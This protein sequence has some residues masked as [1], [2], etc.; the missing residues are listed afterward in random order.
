MLPAQAV[1][2]DTFSDNIAD[3]LQSHA[4]ARKWPSQLMSCA[5]GLQMP[6][7]STAV[8]RSSASIA[9]DP[10]SIL[11]GLGERAQFLARHVRAVV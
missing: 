1:H 5:Q 11:T 2:R 9:I 4:A 10:T 6:A 3:W 8:F 7:L